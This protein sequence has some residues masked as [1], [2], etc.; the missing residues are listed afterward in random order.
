M[1]DKFKNENNLEFEVKDLYMTRLGYVRREDLMTY[2]WEVLPKDSVNGDCIIV[3]RKGKRKVVNVINNR[4]YYLFQGNKE[5]YNHVGQ[6]LANQLLPLEMTLYDPTITSLSL[7]D[8]KTLLMSRKYSDNIFERLNELNNKIN[9]SN[10]SIDEKIKLR[11]D[12]INIATCYIEVMTKIDN[13]LELN[14]I[15]NEYFSLKKLI[16][17]QYD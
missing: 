7:L 11:Q 9:T 13:D 8:I 17:K 3:K 4:E 12:L 15:N 1:F 14:N 10:I 6:I 2:F 16:L 5:L